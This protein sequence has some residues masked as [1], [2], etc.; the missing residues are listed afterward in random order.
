MMRRGPGRFP[1]LPLALV[2]LA[3]ALIALEV[4]T[5]DVVVVEALALVLEN[6]GVGPL[7]NVGTHVGTL[8]LNV[9]EITAQAVD[10]P[11]ECLSRYRHFVNMTIQDA[12]CIVQLHELS[13]QCRVCLL[14]VPQPF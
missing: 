3:L 10:V 9:L 1:R 11:P 14:Q 8:A 4:A 2:A 6:T 7:P 13:R 12:E 5:L